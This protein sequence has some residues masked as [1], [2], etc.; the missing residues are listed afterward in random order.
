[1][2][3]SILLLASLAAIPPLGAADAAGVPADTTDTPEPSQGGVIQ[4]QILSERSGMALP[5]VLVEVGRDGHYRAVL[6]D[7]HGHY[8]LENVPPGRRTVRA[9]SLDH[10]PHEVTVDVPR[11][12]RISLDLSLPIQP[13]GLPTITVVTRHTEGIFIDDGGDGLHRSPASTRL[14]AL[15]ASPGAAEIGL[16]RAARS[17]NRMDPADPSSVLFVRGGGSDL[18]LVL[19]DGAPVTSPFH[20][21]GLMEPLPRDVIGSSRVRVGGA[22]SRLDGGLSYILEMETRDGRSENHSAAGAADL[23]GGRVRAEGPLAGGSYLA[24]ARG[25]HAYGADQMLEHPLPLGYSDALGRARW[26]LSSTDT[27]A[28]TG[29]WNRESVRMS[30]GNAASLPRASWGNRAGSIRY[31]GQVSGS[32]LRVSVG[33]GE[34]HARIPIGVESGDLAAGQSRRLRVLAEARSRAGPLD[35]STGAGY[36]RNGTHYRAFSGGGSTELERR[37]TGHTMSAF[38]DLGWEASPQVELRAGLRSNFFLN[39]DETRLSPRFHLE[40][41]PRSDLVL[42]ASAGRYF[43]YVRSATSL[44]PGSLAP[45]EE[46]ET[47]SGTDGEPDLSVA[48]ASHFVLSARGRPASDLVMGGE[49]YLKNFDN[50]PGGMDFRTVGLDSWVDWS[51]EEWAAWAGLVMN[52]TW[53]P[54]R[55]LTPA[56]MQSEERLKIYE[57]RLVSGGFRAPLPSGVKVS[58]EVTTSSG[59]PFTPFP[60]TTVRPGSEGGTSSPAGGPSSEVPNVKV[61]ML[62]RTPRSSYLRLDAEVQRSWSTRFMDT[63]VRITPY[64]RVLN[65]LDRKDALFYRL[66]EEGDLVRRRSLGVV[67]ILPVVGLEWSVL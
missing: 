10:A 20:L 59:L 21:G 19:L 28:I 15:E 14:R 57:R 13:I 67:P 6:T 34:F 38:T 60:A 8:R 5:F 65:A 33:G 44:L 58:M 37:A 66:V 35:V 55:A 49:T 63:P 29:F 7:E 36:Q 64:I 1:M 16:A 41:T 53:A 32:Q 52:W 46:G 31:R 26:S 62:I 30:A 18:K 11:D 2:T 42:A 23:V 25:I 40:W 3:T 56:E 12:A 61:P 27:L 54:E 39:V 51:H 50:P 47:A 43:Q 4:G 17:V 22:P 45:W 24:S 48:G 9:R